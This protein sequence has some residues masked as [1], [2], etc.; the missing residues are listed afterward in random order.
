MCYVRRFDPNEKH[1]GSKPYCPLGS[2][3]YCQMDDLEHDVTQEPNH[4]VYLIC[5]LMRH[6]KWGKDRS[7]FLLHLASCSY[8]K[9]VLEYSQIV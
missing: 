6:N 1:L 3:P 4:N 8:S 7:E 2:K 9:S 5:S